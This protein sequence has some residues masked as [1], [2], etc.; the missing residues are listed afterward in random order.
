[1]ADREYQ[2]MP[3]TLETIDRA[4]YNWVN[5]ELDI[6]ST[7]NTGWR[8]VPLVWV[9]A[10]RA[11]QVKHDKDLR[12]ASGVLRLPLITIER[13]SIVKDPTRKGIYQAHIPPRKDAKGGAI[14]ITRRI[15]Q[16]KTG[17]FA[18]ADAYKTQPNF[19]VGGPLVGQQ[20]FP[21]K[22]RKVVYETL[23]MPVPTYINVTYS[24]TLQGE[25]FQQINEMLT[26]FIVRTGQINN[27]FIEAEGHKFEGF[28]PQDFSQN[29]NMANLGDEERKFRTKIDI[30]ILGYVLGAGKNE[31]RPRVSIREN[32]VEVRIPREHVI[33]GDIPTT[34]SGA[35]YRE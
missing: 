10:E 4:L 15:N 14:N 21:Y 2:L 1:M 17:D 16:S 7:T 9:S 33:F 8:K 30:R 6:F 11:F 35:F 29:N 28:L 13:T 31:E 12:D 34:V 5:E 25:Y 26:P 22:N 20:N 23:S 3:S 19:G 27:F 32:I 24:I 18:N